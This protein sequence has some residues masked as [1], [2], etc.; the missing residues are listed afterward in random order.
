MR[1]EDKAGTII[2]VRVRHLDKVLSALHQAV[3]TLQN[4][5]DVQERLHYRRD[6]SEE[7]YDHSDAIQDLIFVIE[8]RRGA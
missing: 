6:W 4:E 8:N 2:T 5:A 3:R 7:L 1:T